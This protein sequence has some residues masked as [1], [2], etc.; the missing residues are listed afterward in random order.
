MKNDR[1]K[2]ASPLTERDW[3]TV[4]GQIKA[5]SPFNFAVLD[6]FLVENYAA[7]LRRALLALPQWHAREIPRGLDGE[8]WVARQ[9]FLDSPPLPLVEEIADA[10]TLVLGGTAGR[11]RLVRCWAIIAHENRGWFPHC[12]GG[13]LSLNLWL[14]P[15][16]FNQDHNC[17]GLI[18]FDVKRTSEMLPAQYASEKGGCCRYVAEHT[19]G[20]IMTVQHQYNRAVLF[21]AYTFHATDRGT[22]SS[23]GRNVGRMNLTYVFE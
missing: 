6:N 8:R 15:D 12:D 4:Y 10:I 11:H 23:G 17:G 7:A 14:T 1:F 19:R 5:S 13:S 20:D 16:R 3:Q 21:D 22:F 9:L 2:P 18:F